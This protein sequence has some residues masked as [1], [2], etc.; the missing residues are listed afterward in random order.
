[1]KNLPL[2]FFGIFFVLA[3]SWTGLI[4]SSVIQY[5]DLKP[6][7]MEEGG[8]PQPQ[9]RVG[10]AQQG[11]LVYISQGCIYCHSQQVRRKGFGADWERGW[12]NRQSVP[13]D[14]ILQERVLLGT[15]RTGPDLMTIGERQPSADWHHQHL[16]NP[17]FT[18]PG[19]IMP[20]FRYLYRTQKI[21]DAPSPNALKIPDTFP[22]EKPEPGY[23]IVPTE[24]AEQLVAY[25]LSLKLNYELPESRNA[26]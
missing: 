4:L 11:K 19:S 10:V 6:I 24:R 9:A 20:P 7:A 14:Y 18:S 3:F 21:G 15:S 1:M 17:Q 2:L 8:V 13:R 5:G 25:M 22:E 12:G 26:E 16:Y 23:E